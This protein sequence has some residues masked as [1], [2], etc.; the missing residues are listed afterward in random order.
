MNI[1]DPIISQA[2]HNPEGLALCAPGVD[3]VSYSRLEASINNVA[4]R[5]LGLGL[6]P[7]QIVAV[8]MPQHPVLH[9]VLLLGLA[10]AGI[11]TAS[12]TARKLPASLNLAGVICDGGHPHGGIKAIPFD[13]SWMMGDGK[14]G[15]FGPGPRAD[16]LCRIMLTS[17]TTGE[18]KVI[19]LT[20]G[21]M[22]GR[23]LRYHMLCGSA[24]PFSSRMFCDVTLAT[25]FGF[26]M[27]LY[28][29]CKGG[30]F[31][32][33]GNN[34]ETMLRA[35]SSYQVTG[36]VVSPGTL[37]ELLAEYD[38][39][40]CRHTFD[41]IFTGGSMLSARLAERVGSRMGANILGGYGS[42]EAGLVACAPA[43]TMRGV[44]SAVGYVSPGISVEIVDD[45][46]R[47]V[48]TGQSGVVRMRGDYVV[49]GYFNDPEASAATFRGGWFYPGDIGSF[50]GDGMFVVSGRQK[51]VLNLGG[52]KVAPETIEHVIAAFDLGLPSA[53]FLMPTAD[54]GNEIWVAIETE[55]PVDEA[56]LREHC[57]K[58]L[59][60][61]FMPKR[62]VT[63]RRLPRNAMGKLERAELSQTVAA[64]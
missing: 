31:F 21:M 5:A 2:L 8:F 25:G 46:D 48:P 47:P 41:V 3:I 35:L 37:P 10:R 56:K 30:A 64:K 40:R 63:V 1:T 61:I 18:P 9:A 60:N 24:L 14:S 11:V 49:E 28:M 19:A 20:H 43:D 58:S 12:I 38:T 59:P 4:R 26:T 53:A 52:E 50:A 45:D 6:A 17:G 62:F 57:Q 29:L 27:F 15:G 13:M 54:G 36:L 16:D 23:V 55:K 22:L 51:A 33:R 42:A 7:G 39:H 34:A 44:Q 32:M